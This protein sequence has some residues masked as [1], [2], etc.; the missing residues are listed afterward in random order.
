[1]TPDTS[2]LTIPGYSSCFFSLIGILVK[3]L[4]I[5]WPKESGIDLIYK[6]YCQM[7]AI[8]I[9]IYI[10]I[11]YCNNIDSHPIYT[12]YDVCNGRRHN[13]HVSTEYSI[14]SWRIEGTV[15]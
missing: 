11:S 5:L 7:L 8:Y 10:T 4:S 15:Q 9:K 2:S 3:D 12:C 6:I 1:M 13:N 14:Y